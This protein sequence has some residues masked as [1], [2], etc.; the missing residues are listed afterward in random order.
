MAIESVCTKLGLQDTEE[1][2]AEVNRVLRS[3]H[4]PK[5]N[6]SKAQ[7]QAIRELKRDGTP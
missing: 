3:S 6:L 1:L 4:P 2:R 5:S 7:F